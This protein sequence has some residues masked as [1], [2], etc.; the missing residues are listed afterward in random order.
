MLPNNINNKMIA[1]YEEKQIQGILTENVVTHLSMCS[2]Y[3]GMGRGLRGIFPNLRE[4]AYVERESYAAANLVAKIEE[5]SMAEA[6]VFT[7]VKEFPYGKFRG[8]VDILSAGFPCQPF[9]SSGI[10]KGIEDERHLFPAIAN[11]ID[12]CRP[13]WVALENVEGIISCKYGGEQ[14]T[15]V[16]KYVLGRMEEIGYEGAFTVVSASEEGAPHQRKRVFMLFRNAH[17]DEIERGLGNTEGTRL[18]SLLDGQGEEQSRGASAWPAR[19]GEFQHEWEEPR[20][21]LAYPKDGEDGWDSR[22][23]EESPV[24]ESVSSSTEG[25]VMAD[26]NNGGG[27][28]NS[29]VGQSE[30]EDAQPCGDNGDGY[31]TIEGCIRQSMGNPEHNGLTTS[32][33]GG[34][35]SKEQEEGGM[36]EPSGGCGQPEDEPRDNVSDSKDGRRRGGTSEECEPGSREVREEEC[37]GGEVDSETQRRSRD[38]G[39]VGNAT[40]LG[41]CGGSKDISGLQS[42][43]FGEGLEST[44][45]SMGDASTIRSQQEPEVGSGQQAS[46]YSEELGETKY[47]RQIESSVGGATSRSTKEYYVTPDVMAFRVPR[48]RLLGNGIVP[49]QAERAYRILFARFF[50]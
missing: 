43:M 23:G 21:C 42:E 35:I 38:N 44:S 41:S 27:E 46:I 26:T 16:L 4:I 40:S 17:P 50:K 1:N 45:T 34:S 47:T 11:G 28:S 24:T 3:E 5:G 19:P 49:A 14:D 29:S 25:G 12:L 15:S 7:D 13:N 37:Q 6:L 48:L 31:S 8:C 36:Q 30:A 18:P 20:V 33:T 32:E 10:R 2:G 39:E 9:S 22:V